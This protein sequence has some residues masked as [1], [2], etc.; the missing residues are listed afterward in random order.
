[1]KRTIVFILSF[2]VLFL[3]A[4]NVCAGTSS[5]P[6]QYNISNVKPQIISCSQKASGVYIEWNPVKN[7]ERY[8]VYRFQNSDR[9]WKLI[10]S[11]AGNKYGYS[12]KMS[13]AGNIGKVYKYRIIARNLKY[14]VSSQ[15]SNIITIKI[16]RPSKY[17]ISGKTPKLKACYNSVS[18]TDLRWEAV[19][20]AEKYEVWR[21]RPAEGGWIKVATARGTTQAYDRSTKDN[22]WGRVYRYRIVAVNETYKSSSKT[23]NILTFQRLNPVYFT[24]YKP[25]SPT[26]AELKWDNKNGIDM[27]HGYEIQCATSQADLATGTGTFQKNEICGRYVKNI[28]I[29][30]L[31]PDTQYYMRIR[32]FANFTD[33]SGKTTKTWSQF[34][35]VITLKMDKINN[36]IT[37]RALFIGN[38]NYPNGMKLNG[39]QNDVNAMSRTLQ[40]YN[41]RTMVR[42][43]CTVN[44]ML[45][46][47]HAAFKNANMSDISLFYFSGHGNMEDGSLIGVD[48]RSLTID[49]LA[50]ELIKL[51][52]HFIIIL[53]SCG[54]GNSISKEVGNGFEKRVVDAFSKTDYKYKSGELISNKF[55]VLAGST[56]NGAAVEILTNGISGGEM[57]RAFVAAA[58]C[59]YPS[60]SFSGKI[61]A[62]RN[63]DKSLSL[64]ELYDYIQGKM[65]YSKILCYPMNSA[66]PFMTK[67]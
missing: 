18:G 59:K 23:S 21:Y 14:S 38:S 8:E 35:N 62:D 26:E 24:I 51:P 49:R 44:Q 12:D 57:T 41:Y 7:A 56:A 33:S 25:I 1:M 19:P 48:N 4:V 55:L 40:A 37:Y 13:I 53:D 50:K 3:M 5:V 60:G 63:S 28:I 34:S 47:I 46:N 27:A 64:K 36:N 2:T 6:A 32:C 58:G 65:K 29:N 42:T 45:E 31:K 54:S 17:D 16:S 61:A 22:C 67:K 39:P 66:S 43:D 30:N 52:G 20:E 9:K 11:S 10:G 15:A